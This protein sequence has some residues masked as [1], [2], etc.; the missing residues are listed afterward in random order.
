M[1]RPKKIGLDYFP[2]DLTSD[3]S[4]ELLEAECG[5]EGFAIIIKLWQKI[6]ANG[7]YIE[8]NDDIETL[9][10]RKINTEKTRV[11]S[12]IT[13]CI[14][15]NLL[16]K[17]IYNTY[18]ILTSRGIQK[19]YLKVCSDSKRT[20]V[21]FIKELILVDSEF[22]QVISEFTSINS[23]E[24]GGFCGSLDTKEKEKEKGKEKEKIPADEN[25]DHD[26]LKISSVWTIT[27]I[28][29]ISLPQCVPREIWS[30]WIRYL[31]KTGMKTM[32]DDTVNG[33]LRL[34][35]EWAGED[36]NLHEIIQ[37]C[38]DKGAKS[39]FKPF[40]CN[41]SKSK[42]TGG[43]INPDDYAGYHLPEDD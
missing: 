20:Y 42:S 30:Q 32:V 15:R 25:P 21:P 38:I 17:H 26:P 37:N 24:T 7:Y 40:G 35:T 23:E 3:D 14:K 12:V 8:W 2:M 29:N 16:D 33:Q 6:Y 34:L 4:L 1:A 43:G 36:L 9:F 39:L 31:A 22:T 19:R 28:E 10:A 18:G 11:N 41:S 13:T 27:D 5:L